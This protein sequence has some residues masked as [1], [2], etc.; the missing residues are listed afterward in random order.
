MK[1]MMKKFMLALALLAAVSTVCACAKGKAEAEPSSEE[2]W[3]KEWDMGF[4][5]NSGKSDGEKYEYES[6]RT[7]SDPTVPSAPTVADGRKI[8]RTVG[9]LAETKEFDAV[10]DELA[11]SVKAMGG[12][13]ENYSV[14]SR[15]NNSRAA[16]LVIRIPKDK[17]DLFLEQVKGSA[18]VLRNE[19]HNTDVTLDYT[20][21]ASQLKAL[22]VQE[23]RLLEL[24]EEAKN[25]TELITIEDKLT[26]VR[27]QIERYESRIRSY[28]NQIDYVTVSMTLNEVET[29]TKIDKPTPG[30]R[31]SE[32]F[33]E[34]LKAVGDF[35]VEL[36]VWFVSAL[37]VL[38]TLAAAVAIAV[39]I[40]VA[41][42]KKKRAKRAAAAKAAM[43]AAEEE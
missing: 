12:Y 9:L 36:C 5:Y 11:A 19:E 20:D 8:V 21:T 31:M 2:L 24:L 26:S 40:V 28:D 17:A 7:D 34:S 33:M 4:N 3:A 38:L 39:V 41:S 10:L 42:V 13:F 29:E 27:Y 30:S 1:K 18:H 22:R 14:N 43:A 32:G 37:P 15:Y 6:E 23:E 25:L 35:F 16:T